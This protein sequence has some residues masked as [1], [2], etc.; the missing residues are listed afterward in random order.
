MT[1]Q[2]TNERHQMS[3]EQTEQ[4]AGVA[5]EVVEPIKKIGELVVLLPEYAEFLDGLKQAHQAA[6]NVVFDLRSTRG[7]EEAR[8]LR[9]LLV[10]S[11]T[12]IEKRRLEV[13]AKDRASIA[14]RIRLRDEGAALMVDFV[15]SLEDP[16]DE[17]IRQDEQRREEEREQALSLIHISEPTRPCH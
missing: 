10:S 4:S 11:R 2:A 15:R 16:L 1:R 8:R 7:N 17:A 12:A 9:K 6:H 14:E 13:N 5:D 3:E